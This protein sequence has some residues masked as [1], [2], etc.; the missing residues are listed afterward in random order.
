MNIYLLLLLLIF[1]I[2]GSQAMVPLEQA[3]KRLFTGVNPVKRLAVHKLQ[4][5]FFIEKTKS[6][7]VER[8]NERM[9]YVHDNRLEEK[10]KSLVKRYDKELG[11]FKK[12]GGNLVDRRLVVQDHMEPPYGSISFLRVIYN[13]TP[14]DELVFS[15]T[16]FRNGLNQI[17]TAGHNLFVDEE[18]IEE[19]C[20]KRKIPLKDFKFNK[21]NITVEAFFGF[22]QNKE[23]ESF[24]THL[25]RV[26]GSHCS[27]H[28]ERDF[29]VVSLSAEKSVFLDEHVGALSI[30]FLPDQPHEYL[31][32]EVSIVGYPGE[33]E[34]IEMHFHSG[35]IKSIDHRGIV[36]Y[37]VDTS[38]G[39]SGSPGFLDLKKTGSI[40]VANF[41][42][43]LVHTHRSK[44]PLNA[45]VKIDDD[46][47]EFMERISRTVS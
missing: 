38:G 15:G 5:E 44:D 31:D 13:M 19:T 23:G 35:P 25:S 42:A 40:G 46:L 2:T 20:V 43:C 29:G 1:S 11:L 28:N 21:R 47:V 18:L 26:N 33:K 36:Y 4:K 12:V 30:G 6:A 7:T 37:E 24:Y 34:P 17:V 39:N 16:G 32:K 10:E 8:I 22:R 9:L 3:T 14:R 41:P 27:V 45:G